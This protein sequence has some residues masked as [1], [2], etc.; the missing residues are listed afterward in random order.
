MLTHYAVAVL[1]RR[2][3]RLLG[4]APVIA[5]VSDLGTPGRCSPPVKHIEPK[6]GKTEIEA[7]IS[8][9]GAL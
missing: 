6:R 8:Y 1:R 5:R 4:G 2:Q 9:T 7:Q 3:G